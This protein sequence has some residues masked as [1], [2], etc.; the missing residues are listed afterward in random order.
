MP[1]AGEFGGEITRTIGLQYTRLSESS[2]TYS[3][4]K[5]QT[6]EYVGK[7]GGTWFWQW[8]FEY[9]RNNEV[10]GHTLSTIFAQ[11]ASEGQKPA[12]LPGHSNDPYTGAQ[13]CDDEQF[14]IKYK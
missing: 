5:K 7:E 10:Q 3:T 14:R 1:G 12:C 8:E 11:T 13:D 9:S 6:K 4:E 2:D